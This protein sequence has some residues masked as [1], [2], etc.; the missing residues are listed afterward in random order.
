MK[1]VKVLLIIS[2][3][4][5]F[6]GCLEDIANRFEK[7]DVV[8]VN[9]SV[10]TEENKTLIKNIQASRGE[11]NKLNA[12]G[13]VAPDKFPGI[14]VK[15]KQ[16]INVSKPNLVKDISVPNGINYNGTGN[17]SFTVQLYENELN[18]TMPVYIYSEIIDN[19]SMRP[20]R[21]IIEVNFTK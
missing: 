5:L 20:A 8:Y 9:L 7:V 21:S 14:Y 11:L 19:K 2:I 12:P 3:V 1:S 17:Y 4:L 18:E 6:T 10:V 15:I 13:F 16:S